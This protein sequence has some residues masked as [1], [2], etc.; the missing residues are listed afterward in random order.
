MVILLFGFVPERTRT[1]PHALFFN[2]TEG[3]ETG[4]PIHHVRTRSNNQP[5]KKVVIPDLNPTGV[6]EMKKAVSIT[7]NI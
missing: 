3:L 1:P 4:F 2:P 6:K 5:S 7:K